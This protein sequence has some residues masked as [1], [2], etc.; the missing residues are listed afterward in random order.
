MSGR[1]RS[2]SLPES[3]TCLASLL[4]SNTISTSQ[5]LLI[6]RLARGGKP[7][8]RNDGKKKKRA[9]FSA[10]LSNF[11][12]PF[13]FLDSFISKH[14]SIF[15][16]NKKNEETGREEGNRIEEEK[17]LRSFFCMEVFEVVPRERSI[18]NS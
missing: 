2:F 8:K 12:A 1:S 16:C 4:K 9:S 10:S 13:A 15:G 14:S 18:L 17:E 3:G 11:N 5:T 6:C 7:K